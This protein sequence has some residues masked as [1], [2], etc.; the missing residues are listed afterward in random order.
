MFLIR[1]SP[2]PSYTQPIYLWVCPVLSMSNCFIKNPYP[3]FRMTFLG[4]A[5]SYTPAQR[6]IDIEFNGLA[7]IQPRRLVHVSVGFG[8][9]FLYTEVLVPTIF[10][11]EWQA[12]SAI[13]AITVADSGP[14]GLPP[15]PV[16]FYPPFVILIN[17]VPQYAPGF[18]MPSGRR[19]RVNRIIGGGQGFRYIR[20]TRPNPQVE[21]VRDP[22]AHPLLFN[23]LEY[24]GQFQNWRMGH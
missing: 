4:S 17:G 23:V 21:M 11:P 2:D 22:T 19:L 5:G 24:G 10:G 15:A 13:P 3:S 12:S 6:Q 16:L 20:H 8:V 7:A 9:G 1:L 14:M 18:P